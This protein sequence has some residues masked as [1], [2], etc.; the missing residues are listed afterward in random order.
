MQQ[1]DS[2][3]D[4]LAATIGDIIKEYRLQNNKGS[5]NKFA[6]EY[7]LDVGNT[8]RVENGLIDVKLVTLWKISEALGLKTSEIV[9]KV[10]EKLGEDFLFYE[11]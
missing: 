8:S 10:E 11:V 1:K 7:D 5:I 6:H 2:K 9:R 4:L 3:T